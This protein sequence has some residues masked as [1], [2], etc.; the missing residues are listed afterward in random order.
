MNL[1]LTA[2]V[3]FLLFFFILLLAFNLIAY[4]PADPFVRLFFD[5]PK[6]RSVD[7]DLHVEQRYTV[8]FAALFQCA[9][10]ELPLALSDNL[11]SEVSIPTQWQR[12][13][14]SGATATVVSETRLDF[15]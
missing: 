6:L 10:H 13:L 14:V 3:I 4:H 9:I 2:M 11:S 5:E 7:D 1:S 15:Y 12:Y 8:F